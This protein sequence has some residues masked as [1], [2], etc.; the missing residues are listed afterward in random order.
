MAPLEVLFWIE[1]VD[2]KSVT[3]V[4]DVVCASHKGHLWTSQTLAAIP[5]L[6][7]QWYELFLPLSCSLNVR[8]SNLWLHL[9]FRSDVWPE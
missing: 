2:G 8:N 9:H 5:I 6:S 1:K 3:H 4:R 7:P